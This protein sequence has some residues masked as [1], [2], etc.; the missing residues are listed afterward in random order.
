MEIYGNN[1]NANW[2]NDSTSTL[3]LPNAVKELSVFMLNG[4][5]NIKIEDNGPTAAS[6]R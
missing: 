6:T 3:P 5:V 1:F 2:A 4:G